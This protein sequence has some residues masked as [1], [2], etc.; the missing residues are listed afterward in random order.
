MERWWGNLVGICADVYVIVQRLNGK[1][2]L[3]KNPNSAS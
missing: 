2:T 1:T 3:W